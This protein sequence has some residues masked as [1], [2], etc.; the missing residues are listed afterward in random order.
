MSASTMRRR[1]RA[2]RSERRWQCLGEPQVGAPCSVRHRGD[3]VRTVCDCKRVTERVW[4]LEFAASPSGSLPYL[5]N[6]FHMLSAPD[7]APPS[8]LKRVPSGDEPTTHGALLLGG[9]AGPIPTWRRR[10][11]VHTRYSV[12]P[13]PSASASL[14]ACNC[15]ASRVRLRS[16]RVVGAVGGVR[17][18]W[19]RPLRGWRVRV[20]GVRAS[21][22]HALL[23]ILSLLCN[24]TIV[25]LL[26]SR[27]C[28]AARLSPLRARPQVR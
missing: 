4:A 1:R 14:R 22:L 5:E 26:D 3:I 19:M 13:L 24:S 18:S 25:L 20:G 10:R 21:R 28:A 15:R 8:W 9:P 11:G 23:K 16:S 17:A 6:V 7:T 2:T 27:D 12:H